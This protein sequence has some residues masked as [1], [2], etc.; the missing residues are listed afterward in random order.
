M[1][2][3]KAWERIKPVSLEQKA[4]DVHPARHGQPLRAHWV[5]PGRVWN[6]GWSMVSGL[7]EQ[8]VPLCECPSAAVTWHLSH[9]CHPQLSNLKKHK[10][11][12]PYFMRP[13]VWNLGVGK[14][15]H[16]LK[17]LR[18]DFSL[19]L[20]AFG[21]CQHPW[22]SLACGCIITISYSLFTW[23]SFLLSVSL[24]FCLCKDSCH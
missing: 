9:F 8:Q 19:D 3:E 15:S 10:C 18:D 17:V 14:P 21:G 16:T 23:T 24:L 1:G 5:P 6:L 7:Q 13:E 4:K 2:T 11:I 22:H 12:A 20:L